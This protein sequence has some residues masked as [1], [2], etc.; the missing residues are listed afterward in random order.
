MADKAF[1]PDDPM[2]LVGVDLP[3]DTDLLAAGLVE[4]YVRLGASDEALL[5]IFRNP[6]FAGAHAIWRAQGE[7]HVRSLIA[8][9]RARWGYPRYTVRESREA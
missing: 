6:F 1:E 8:R 2:A 7:D 5:A 4:E 3:G 9:A